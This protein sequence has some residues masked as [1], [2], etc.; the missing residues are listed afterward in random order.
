MAAAA[1]LDN[2]EWL[3][4][5]NGSRST[6]SAHRA[7]IFAIAQLSCWTMLFLSLLF[8]DTDTSVSVITNSNLILIRGLFCNS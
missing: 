6:Y 1:I 2:F 4:L 5:G 7:V 8:L 3:Y